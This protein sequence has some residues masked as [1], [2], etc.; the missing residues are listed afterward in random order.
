MQRH[1]IGVVGLLLLGVA[2]G[3]YLWGSADAAKAVEFCGRAGAVLAVWWLAY[4]DLL[5][6][7]RWLLAATPV[8][9]IVLARWPRYLVLAVPL[10]VALAILRPRWGA[11]PPKR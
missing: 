3:T 1:V 9:L 7:P 11:K 5:R 2:G 4:P 6:L 10:V 8:L